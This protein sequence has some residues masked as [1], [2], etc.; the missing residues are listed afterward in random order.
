ME[1]REFVLV[2]AAIV[3]SVLTLFSMLKIW[4]GA[5]WN[6]APDVPVR[7]DDRRWVPMTW[8]VGGLTA[9][10]LVIGVGAEAFLQLAQE[11]ATRVLDRDAYAAAV[12]Q[13]LGKGAAP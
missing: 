10:S 13:Q 3:A 8:V 2:G 5:F 6:A 1:Q 4:N 12:F 11:A 7:T 9:I